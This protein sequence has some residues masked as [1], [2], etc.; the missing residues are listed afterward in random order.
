[1]WENQCSQKAFV[2][3]FYK[4][5]LPY[6]DASLFEILTSAESKRERVPEEVCERGAEMWGA[7]E[8]LW[9]VGRSS[10]QGSCVL[11]KSLSQF[12]IWKSMEK[13]KP[14]MEQYVH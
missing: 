13:R 12:Q 2:Y 11:W 14:S 1:M 6:I 10:T 4:V 7:G 9:W 5:S 3:V 8:K